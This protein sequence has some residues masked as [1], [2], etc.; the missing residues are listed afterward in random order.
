MTY[1]IKKEKKLKMGHM[2]GEDKICMY[3]LCL[4][5]IGV[6]FN[7]FGINIDKQLKTF[8]GVEIL[9]IVSLI[10][11]VN[12]VHKERKALRGKEKYIETDEVDVLNTISAMLLFVGLMSIHNRVTCEIVVICNLVFEQ[13]LRRLNFGSKKTAEQRN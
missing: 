12:T 13:L 1:A 11:V 5:A 2:Q 9:A 10:I 3:L 4:F 8:N 7:L 6:M